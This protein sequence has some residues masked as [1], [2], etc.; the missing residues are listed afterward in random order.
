MLGQLTRYLPS[1]SQTSIGGVRL[2]LIGN[3]QNVAK[4]AHFSHK[5]L[6]N[7]FMYECT[8][9]LSLS[10]IFEYKDWVNRCH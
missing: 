10:L 4:N 7:L 1:G 8:L 5:I 3:S 6:M 9:S 2:F